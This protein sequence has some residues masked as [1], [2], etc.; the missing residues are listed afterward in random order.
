MID[1]LFVPFSSS[2]RTGTGLGLSIVYQIVNAHRGT[3]AVVS[4]PEHGTR[5]T[6][7]LPR[8]LVLEGEQV[9]V[10]AGERVRPQPD[11]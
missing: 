9:T 6:L 11:T 1:R 3:I 7:D 5:F 10:A 8:E 4:Q 2:F